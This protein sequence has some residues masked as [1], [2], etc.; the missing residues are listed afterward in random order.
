MHCLTCQFGSKDHT[1]THLC[2]VDMKSWSF[3]RYR[4]RPMSFYKNHRS[5]HF[6]WRY[7]VFQVPWQ[8]KTW[9]QA[10][11]C[12]GLVGLSVLWTDSENGD[13]KKLWQPT[14]ST[15]HAKIN[16]QLLLL[17]NNHGMDL[18]K[19]VSFWET[20]FLWLFLED[21][22]FL[23]LLNEPPGWLKN[24]EY[25]TAA[26]IFF[27]SFSWCWGWFRMIWRPCIG[28]ISHE[29]YFKFWSHLK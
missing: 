28:Q 11:L 21:D 6:P 2:V 27:Q 16:L 13:V 15:G 17:Q 22:S 1:R 24:Q 14:K 10:R 23:D 19:S 26:G 20:I 18:V 8:G 7:P 5:I 9:R 29:F 4:C 25:I 12:Q 3:W